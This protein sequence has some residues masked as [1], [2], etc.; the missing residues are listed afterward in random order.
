MHTRI[1]PFR[2]INCEFI[3]YAPFF[4][5]SYAVYACYLFYHALLTILKLN[6][7]HIVSTKTLLKKKELH[8][9]TLVAHSRIRKKEYYSLLSGT[10]RAG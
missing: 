5:L 3:R 7:F 8:L 2:V 6:L 10:Q 9:S 4:I 1:L